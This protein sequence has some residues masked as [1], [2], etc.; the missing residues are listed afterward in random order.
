MCQS[1][2]AFFLHAIA[3]IS[4]TRILNIF[5]KPVSLKL[6]PLPLLILSKA[7]EGR[8]KLHFVALKH[9]RGGRA[10]AH[11]H[12]SS[13]GE[14]IVIIKLASDK[15]NI[16][17]RTQAFYELEITKATIVRLISK[18]AIKLTKLAMENDKSDQIFS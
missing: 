11:A 9:G 6:L 14:K 8:N 12:R 16:G 7:N 5:M 17:N 13:D 2:V 10:L 4:L 3:H 1:A 15:L 18:L